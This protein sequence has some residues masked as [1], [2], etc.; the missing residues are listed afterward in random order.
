MGVV[1]LIWVSSVPLLPSQAHLIV[2][3]HGKKTM[4]FLP[5]TQKPQKGLHIIANEYIQAASFLYDKADLAQSMSLL[6][7]RGS[8]LVWYIM[9]MYIQYSSSNSETQN[10][11]SDMGNGEG[12]RAWNAQGEQRLIKRC[13]RQLRKR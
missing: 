9:I 2:I 4:I 5:S 8:D 3:T 6:Q 12:S 10:S 11:A 1:G 7:W 13:S